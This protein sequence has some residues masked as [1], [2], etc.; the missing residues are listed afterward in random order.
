MIIM[1]IIAET[2]RIKFSNWP[3]SVL[4]TILY[5]G[6]CLEMIN[7]FTNAPT[8]LWAPQTCGSLFFHCLGTTDM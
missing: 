3:G 5:L 1:A 6:V 7:Y 8:A 2:P 4:A